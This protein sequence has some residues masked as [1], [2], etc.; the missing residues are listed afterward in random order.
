MFYVEEINFIKIILNICKSIWVNLNCN[1][2][3]LFFSFCKINKG[4]SIN[5]I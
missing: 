5:L 2:I 3:I 4:N 1:V